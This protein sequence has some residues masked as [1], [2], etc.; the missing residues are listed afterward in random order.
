VARSGTGAQR[1]ASTSSPAAARATRRFA[2]RAAAIEA[3]T[4]DIPKMIISRVDCGMGRSPRASRE[5]LRKASAKPMMK[6]V[7]PNTMMLRSPFTGTLLDMIRMRL[8][9]SGVPPGRCD[10]GLIR[11]L[12]TD[13]TL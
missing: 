1:F 4:P 9:M 5:A 11:R 12:V 2:P 13:E 6:A 10:A 7:T 8:N 3:T